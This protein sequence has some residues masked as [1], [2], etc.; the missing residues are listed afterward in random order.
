MPA[1]F[2]PFSEL[3][4]DFNKHLFSVINRTSV[5]TELCLYRAGLTVNYDGETDHLHGITDSLCRAAETNTC[6][7]AEKFGLNS[8][9]R[10]IGDKEI[11]YRAK[12]MVARV[13]RRTLL[14]ICAQC[15]CDGSPPELS[16]MT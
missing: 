2:Y 11:P 4:D 15:E 16:L 9:T 8:R 6:Q 10:L 7:S 12:G 3:V 1:V 13:E 5:K 14:D